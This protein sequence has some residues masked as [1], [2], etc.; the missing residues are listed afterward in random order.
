MLR[1]AGR[2]KTMHGTARIYPKDGGIWEYGLWARVS[3]PGRCEAKGPVRRVR[4]G[5]GEGP[6]PVKP[7]P[8]LVSLC[9]AMT[10]CGKDGIV[11]K[12]AA[13]PGVV[14]RGRRSE[15]A[16]R[17]A[18]EFHFRTADVLPPGE[19]ASYP[20]AWTLLADLKTELVQVVEL[21]AIEDGDL[22]LR[23]R[24][25]YEYDRPLPPGF[26]QAPG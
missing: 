13:R 24:C 26:D 17:P 2:T 10:Y 14:V 3:G 16:G 9:N 7:D 23:A 20:A 4:A 21:Y 6:A 8:E 12:L 18:W 15:S 5:P 1:A 22:R 11:T 25:E 19:G